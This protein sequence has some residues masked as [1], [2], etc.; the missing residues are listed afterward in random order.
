MVKVDVAPDGGRN[1]SSSG[2]LGFLIKDL[3]DRLLDRDAHRPAIADKAVNACR[4]WIT[5]TPIFADTKV[6]ENVG[7][8]RVVSDQEGEA[9]GAS[10]SM[11]WNGRLEENLGW[12]FAIGRCVDYTDRAG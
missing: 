7:V 11:A 4:G 5:I 12:H 9:R 8:G 10:D 1:I 3:G 2:D 6:V